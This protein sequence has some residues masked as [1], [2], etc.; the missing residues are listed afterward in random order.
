MLRFMYILLVCMVL[1]LLDNKW[2]IDIDLPKAIQ[3]KEEILH[4]TFKHINVRTS[5]TKNIWYIMGLQVLGD[6]VCW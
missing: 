6:S 2:G 5:M 3:I 4:N 1:L